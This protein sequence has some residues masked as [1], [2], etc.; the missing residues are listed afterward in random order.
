MSLAP[1]SHYEGDWEALRGV[2]GGSPVDSPWVPGIPK[3]PL[4]RLDCISAVDSAHSS[5]AGFEAVGSDY[6]IGRYTRSRGFRLSTSTL[7]YARRKAVPKALGARE[8]PTN[9]ARTKMVT[10]YGRIWMN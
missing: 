8:R 7:P 9:P 3:A 5:G 1:G 4:R 10:R 6:L 2:S